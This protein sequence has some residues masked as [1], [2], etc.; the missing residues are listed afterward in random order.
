MGQ[1]G[2]G[3]TG[4]PAILGFAL[5]KS[6]M[7][8]HPGLNGDLPVVS[9]GDHGSWLALS[10]LTHTAG[11]IAATESGRSYNLFGRGP[12]RRVQAPWVLQEPESSLLHV[13]ALSAPMS[14]RVKGY[15]SL[16]ADTSQVILTQSR[17]LFLPM[18]AVPLPILQNVTACFS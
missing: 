13:P 4:L 1:K 14:R 6:P 2:V 8:P 7:S 12:L 17:H 3:T 15:A 9:S 5:D 16:A 11:P 18:A 10:S